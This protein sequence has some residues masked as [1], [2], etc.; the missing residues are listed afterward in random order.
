MS[1]MPP[2]TTNITGPNNYLS[3]ISLNI[4]GL[5]SHLK[6]HKLTDWIY[7]QDPAFCYIQETICNNKDRHYLRVK[8]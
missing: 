3:L 5:N 4:D 1:I 8:A 6:R 7:K 2:K